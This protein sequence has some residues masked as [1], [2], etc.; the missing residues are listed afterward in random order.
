MIT[1]LITIVIKNFKSQ[2]FDP[3]SRIAVNLQIFVLFFFCSSKSSGGLTIFF[4]DNDFGCDLTGLSLPVSMEFWV[5][6]VVEVV[7]V[8]EVV[9]A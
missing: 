7:E 6:V 5:V 9:V 4:L 2:F 1:I 3:T 8:V